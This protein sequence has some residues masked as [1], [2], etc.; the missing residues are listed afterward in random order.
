MLP[1]TDQIVCPRNPDHGLVTK[2]WLP[3]E[4]RESLTEAAGDVFEID[5]MEC[6][7][8]EYRPSE[9]HAR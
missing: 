4:E 9:F 5:C 7:K 6:G 3:L 2:R 1:A 8:Y